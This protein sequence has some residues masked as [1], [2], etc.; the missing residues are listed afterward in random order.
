MCYLCITHLDYMLLVWSLPKEVPKKMQANFCICLRS[1]FEILDFFL[2]AIHKKLCYRVCGFCFILAICW[3]IKRSSRCHFY[4]LLTEQLSFGFF[5]L[6]HSSFVIEDTGVNWSG[7]I[8]K[9]CIFFLQIST[10]WRVQKQNKHLLQSFLVTLIT[11]WN[12][13]IM[14]SKEDLQTQPK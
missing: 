12:C 6:F 11:L 14:K 7:W 9:Y 10:F 3:V 8:Q 1:F 5:G 2:I 13:P 4:N